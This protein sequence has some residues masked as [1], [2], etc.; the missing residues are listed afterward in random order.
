MEFR[1]TFSHSLGCCF[2]QLTVSFT[3][4]KLYWLVLCDNLAQAGV[5]TEKG[6]IVGGAI[7]GLVVLDS[8]RKQA[9]QDRGSNH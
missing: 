3:L 6:A 8:I 5:I 9:G 4:K 7:P 2:I 1:K